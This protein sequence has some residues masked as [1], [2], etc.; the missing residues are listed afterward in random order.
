MYL[1]LFWTHQ[2]SANRPGP[3]EMQRIRR[4]RKR[5]T[6]KEEGMALYLL[7]NVTVIPVAFHS[8]SPQHEKSVWPPSGR[9][10]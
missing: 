8:L 6:K 2:M 9:T 5:E 7:S 1:F 10:V 4:T 3:T